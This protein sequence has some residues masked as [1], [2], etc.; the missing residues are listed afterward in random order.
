MPTTDTVPYLCPKCVVCGLQSV[1]ELSSHQIDRWKGGEY[2][3]SVFPDLMP[4]DR[5]VLISGT[6]PKCF[7]ELFKEEE[8]E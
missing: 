1:M 2:V 7:N 6:H 8:D 5:E 4:E 3:Q